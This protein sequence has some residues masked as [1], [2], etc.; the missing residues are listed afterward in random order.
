MEKIDRVTGKRVFGVEPTNEAKAAV[1]WEAFKPDTEPPRTAHTED[2]SSQIQALIADLRASHEP[3]QN[4]GEA[5]AA[6]E[7]KDFAEEQGGVY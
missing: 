1:I 3:Q 6:V 5:P 2:Y 4:Q 7:Q